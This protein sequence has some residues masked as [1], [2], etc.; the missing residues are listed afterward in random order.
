MHKHDRSLL[1]RTLKYSLLLARALGKAPPRVYFRIP[2]I[3]L[4]RLE[5]PEN[6]L[7]FVTQIIFSSNMAKKQ[8]KSQQNDLVSLVGSGK[9]IAGIDE[10]GRGAWAGP[11][12]AA[13]VGWFGRCPIK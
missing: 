6:T 10:A 11:V 7:R 2:Y 13:C 12:V 5:V 8:Y 3:D 1:F 9:M 4:Y